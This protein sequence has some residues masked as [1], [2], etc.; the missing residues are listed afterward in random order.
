VARQ[1]A[2][3]QQLYQQQRGRNKNQRATGENESL[4]D[5]G[6]AYQQREQTK[7]QA[8]PD[9][10]A[11]FGARQPGADGDNGRQQAQIALRL[12]RPG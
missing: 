8:K 3:A 4:V 10:P 5:D 12:Q 2:H 11:K 6:N 1:R 9:V 7:I